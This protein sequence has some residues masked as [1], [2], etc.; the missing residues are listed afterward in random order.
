MQYSKELRSEVRPDSTWIWVTPS[1]W[2]DAAQWA[3]SQGLVRG[4]WLTAAHEGDQQFSILMCLSDASGAQK[5]I[6][7]TKTEL[8]ITSASSIFS[9]LEFHE[10]ETRQLLGVNFVNLTNDEP[11]L[12]L[13]VEGFPLRRDFA[14]TP[15]VETP[16]PGQVDPEKSAK[17]RTQPGVNQ[18]WLP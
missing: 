16:W 9:S 3:H 15:R 17:R 18:E 10:R 4:E 8:E 7:V 13:Q 6:F 1:E 5:H 11:A 12:Q 14:L 2:L